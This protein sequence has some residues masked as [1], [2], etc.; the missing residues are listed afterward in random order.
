MR[1]VRIALIG[2][3]A[4]AL[5]GCAT[6]GSLNIDCQHFAKYI[7]KMPRS[8]LVQDI[9][10][11]A[12]ESSAQ[13]VLAEGDARAAYS[14][15]ASLAAGA[16][17][18][19][20]VQ[21]QLKTGAGGPRTDVLLLSGGGQWGAFGVGFLDRL[22]TAHP[23][24][25]P[26]AKTITGVSTGGLQ[27]LFLAVGTDAAFEA[28]KISYAPKSESEVVNRNLKPLAV[29]T[30]SIAG[31]KPLKR[32][33]LAA[34]CNDGD[35]AKGCPLIDALASDA[36]ADA[37]IGFVDAKSGDFYHVSVKL[38]AHLPKPEAQQCIAGAALAS[39]AMPV[40]FQQVKVGKRVYYDGGVRQ[41]VFEAAVAR[42]AFA[43]A[44]AAGVAD[45]SGA[46]T[47]YVIRNGPTVLNEDK[48][49]ARRADALTNALRAQAIVVNQ[50]EVQSIADLRL[51]NPT[52]PIVLITA[53]G[54]T[55]FGCPKRPDKAMFSP[56]FMRCLTRFGA[57][58]A[59]R[60]P[61]W[62]PLSK[63]DVGSDPVSLRLTR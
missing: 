7:V 49:P 8:Q 50:L 42:K 43:A 31:L 41:S 11:D 37:F 39:A 60:N 29:I 32:K 9:Q 56:L 63:L 47:L 6:R 1:S 19:S 16:Q 59:D 15:E 2:M 17:R 61:P 27:A 3:L 40:F 54:Y 33:V 51:S 21:P 13:F 57:A 18:A 55:G 12:G 5:G 53:D 52:G 22:R 10:E 14:L 44:R 24:D 36:S 48:A 23:A 4:L 46:P 58:R 35:A 20:G 38:L 25:F 28:L 62:R 26:R 34:L 30:G 45:K